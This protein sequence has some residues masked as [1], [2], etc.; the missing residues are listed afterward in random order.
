M[1]DKTL[2]AGGFL[3]TEV[4]DID[5]GKI[6]RLSQSFVVMLPLIF[7]SK[8]SKHKTNISESV[9][10]NYIIYYEM[11]VRLKLFLKH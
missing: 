6:K 11:N 1:R 3:A 4:R 8:K 10:H 2:P 7:F 5:D 9:A